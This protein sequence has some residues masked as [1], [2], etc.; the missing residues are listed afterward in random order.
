MNE[1]RLARTTPRR[2]FAALLAIAALA[3]G[4]VFASGCGDD[5]GSVS[6][7]IQQSV[8]EGVDRAQEGLET[9][10]EEVEQGVEEG[11]EKAKEGVESGKEEAEKGIEE[12]KKQAEEGIEK[13]KEE[14]ERYS[15]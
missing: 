15:P 5:A 2:L 11:V 10:A 4:A 3:V 8:E 13:A 14:A 6:D 1:D 9:G 12:G 7:E